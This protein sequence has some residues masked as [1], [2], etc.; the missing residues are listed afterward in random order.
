MTDRNAADRA[1]IEA[2]LARTDPP[3]GID[4]GEWDRYRAGLRRVLALWPACEEA[5]SRLRAAAGGQG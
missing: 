1:M 5:Q 2:A 3:P 4:P